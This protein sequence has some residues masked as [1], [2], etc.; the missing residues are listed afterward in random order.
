MSAKT[1]LSS[2]GVGRRHRLPQLDPSRIPHKPPLHGL[3]HRATTSIEHLSTISLLS[4]HMFT[5]FVS[6][7]TQGKNSITT[8][9]SGPLPTS[10]NP[11]SKRSSAF[12]VNS[13]LHLHLL[14]GVMFPSYSLSLLVTREEIFVG[15]DAG[16]KMTRVRQRRSVNLSPRPTERLRQVLVQLVKRVV[17]VGMVYIYR[18]RRIPWALQ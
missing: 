10:I 2:G 15:G 18:R 7:T 3:L 5:P 12:T 6:F 17:V 9:T 11:I 13:L 8:R 14:G 16:L 1:L 4:T